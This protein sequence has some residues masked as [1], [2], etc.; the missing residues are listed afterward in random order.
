[1]TGWATPIL[2]PTIYLFNILHTGE[3]FSQISDKELDS[4][5]IEAR[6]EMDNS[7]RENLYHKAQQLLYDRAYLAVLYQPKDLFGVSKRVKW[8]PQP[9]GMMFLGDVK[10]VK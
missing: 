5:L 2:D 3:P 1:M 8:T 10:L 6:Q 9:D 4:I 7:K